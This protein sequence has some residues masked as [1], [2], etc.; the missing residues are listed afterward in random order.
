MKKRNLKKNQKKQRKDFRVKTGIR[1]GADDDPLA[2][3]AEMDDELAV[4]APE[5]GGSIRA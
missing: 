4:E 1:A 2:A 5:A 3:L